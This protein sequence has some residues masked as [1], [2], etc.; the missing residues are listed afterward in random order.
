MIRHR[1]RTISKNDNGASAVLIAFSMVVLLGFAAL[2]LDAT[3]LGFNER[4]QAQS[5][6][7]VGSLAAVQFAVPEDIGNGTCT[8]SATDVAECNGATEAIEVA[9]QTLD[10]SSLADWN[11]SSKCGTPPAGFTV[12]SVSDCVAFNSNLQRAWVR[13]PTIEKP[14]TIARAIGFD[15]VDTSADSIAGA[16][17]EPPGGVLPFLLPGNAASNNYACLKGF[18]NPDWGPCEDTPVSGN[19]GSADFYLYGDVNKEWT[20]KCNGDTNGRLVANIARGVDHPLSTHPTG[21]GSGT[22]ERDNCP[23]FSAEPNIVDSQTGIGS[24]LEQGLVWGGSDYS[25]SPYPGKIWDTGGTTVRNS[26]G[27]NPSTQINDEPLWNFLVDADDDTSLQGTACDDETVKGTPPATRPA[28]ME[29]CL[30]Y[31]KTNGKIVFN[32]DLASSIRFGWV[33]QIYEDTF[34]GNPYYIELFRPVYL[35][36]T[37]YGC[38]NNECDVMHTPGIPEDPETCPVEP[39]ETRITCGIPGQHNKNLQAITAWILDPSIVPDNAKTPSPGS[40]NQ[41]SYSLIE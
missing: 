9:N 4:R 10:D 16:G 28:A 6:A 21:S 31:A 25:P 29:D 35:D 1:I 5:A 24:N 36:T 17:V 39:A 3:G 14:T 8:G 26:G 11:D 7:D 22:V 13:I 41:R 12:T 34:S 40:V 38:N 27:A 15:S 2:A 37:W 18:A 32:N 19:F 20:E 33:P 23:V 30:T